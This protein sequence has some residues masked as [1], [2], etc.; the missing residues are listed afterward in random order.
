MMRLILGVAVSAC[1]ASA[2][3]N[4]TANDGAPPASP[5]ADW[6]SLA[7]AASFRTPLTARSAPQ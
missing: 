5:H 6:P 4:G 1:C 3:P 7:R 2:M